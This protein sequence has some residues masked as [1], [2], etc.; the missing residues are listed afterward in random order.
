M[1][2]DAWGIEDGYWDIAG[3]WHDTPEPTR[4]ALRLA[5]GGLGD[6]ARSEEHTSELQSHSDLVCR[7]LLEKKRIRAVPSDRPP[8]PA[9]RTGDC[10]TERSRSPGSAPASWDTGHC[11]MSTKQRTCLRCNSRL[12]LLA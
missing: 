11:T 3:Q 8:S 7:L 1:A 12:P 6:V 9:H 4:R 5:M 2:P 10:A